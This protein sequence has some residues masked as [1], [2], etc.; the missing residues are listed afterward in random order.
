[1]N[2]LIFDIENELDY[3]SQP[4]IHTIRKI[5][6]YFNR[7]SIEGKYAKPFLIK[8]FTT[9]DEKYEWSINDIYIHLSYV[10]KFLLSTSNIPYDFNYI[11]INNKI[12]PIKKSE[13][14]NSFKVFDD[15]AYE[16]EV[17]FGSRLVD[18]ETTNSLCELLEINN[19]EYHFDNDDKPEYIITYPA[20]SHYHIHVSLNGK[21][22]KSNA[23]EISP[24]I[25]D[26]EHHTIIGKFNMFNNKQTPIPNDDNLAII[27]HCS[28]CH[29]SIIVNWWS[30]KTICPF[31]NKPH[32][33]Y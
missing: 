8:F 3:I 2:I 26:Y 32:I 29:K 7:S 13:S 31:C 25:D 30:I 4:N 18:K 9:D 15:E 1:M 19:I 20:T 14:I 21:I 22:N 12:F 10:P 5:F 11:D 23:Y 16:F 6:Y 33:V 28:N 24:Y 17:N 27:T